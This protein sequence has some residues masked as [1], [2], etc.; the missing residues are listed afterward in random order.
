MATYLPE[1]RFVAFDH[2]IALSLSWL[3]VQ[4][5]ESLSREGSVPLQN[6]GILGLCDIVALSL[7]GRKVGSLDSDAVDVALSL[8][9]L[10]ITGESLPST[11]PTL[12]ASRDRSARLCRL[13]NRVSAA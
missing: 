1:I 13:G 3:V 8:G 9:N 11:I 7:L 4:L 2:V 6:I 5:V 12:H 10:Y